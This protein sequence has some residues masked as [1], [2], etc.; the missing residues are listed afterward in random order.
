MKTKP[1]GRRRSNHEE[2]HK[3]VWD[4]VQIFVISLAS[5]VTAEGMLSLLPH[6]ECN[7]DPCRLGCVW[8]G[9]DVKLKY[10]PLV[11]VTLSPTPLSLERRFR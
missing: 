4:C 9:G 8:G 7:G 11:R 2:K 6:L 10:A 3:M 1:P 5:A